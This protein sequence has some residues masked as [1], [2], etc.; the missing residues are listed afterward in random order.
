MS[1]TRAVDG[2]S[3]PSVMEVIVSSDKLRQF[4]A[5]PPITPTTFHKFEIPVPE[6]FRDV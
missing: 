4:N 6:E 1:V 2:N 3:V 5:N